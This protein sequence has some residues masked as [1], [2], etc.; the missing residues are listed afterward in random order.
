MT[1]CGSHQE[2]SVESSLARGDDGLSPH[3]SQ[4]VKRAG[5]VITCSSF[6]VGEGLKLELGE[7]NKVWNDMYRARIEG[8]AA[9]DV[10][11]EVR[12]NCSFI[13]VKV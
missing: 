12:G 3:M 7:N 4:E 8:D 13:A 5:Y 1:C 9:I 10:G 6:V 11:R 2:G